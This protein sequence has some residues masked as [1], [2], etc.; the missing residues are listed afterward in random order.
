MSKKKFDP[1]VD[2]FVFREKNI[3][4][5]V[6]KY[7]KEVGKSRAWKGAI[8]DPDLEYVVINPSCSPQTKLKIVNKQE[9]ERLKTIFGG[10]GKPVFL[11]KI[12]PAN[13]KEVREKVPRLFE[14][15]I[16]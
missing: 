15:H 16:Y 13:M 14:G 12:L 4:M 11:G 7:K 3:L 5:A 10:C 6:N 9:K 1:L 2:P 8:K